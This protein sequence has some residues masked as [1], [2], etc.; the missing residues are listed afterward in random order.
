MPSRLLDVVP[1]SESPDLIYLIE[2]AAPVKMSVVRFATLSHVWG[3]HKPM[4]LTQATPKTTGWNSRRI[5]PP[6][7][8]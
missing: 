4:V 6:V 2:R 7:L 5:T 3:Q 8:S 1:R